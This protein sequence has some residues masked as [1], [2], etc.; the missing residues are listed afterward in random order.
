MEETLDRIK[1]TETA[2]TKKQAQRTAFF[3]KGVTV[4]LLSGISYG[5]YSAF[6]T[7]A[8][9]KGVWGDWYG[10]N[11]FGLSVFAITFLI[12]TLGSGVNDAC[13]AIWA[14]ANAAKQGKAKEFFRSV[15]TKPGLMMILAALVGGPIASAAY[16]IA[17]QMAGSIVIPI[18][19]LCPAIG[20]I[21]SRILFK[22]PLEKRQLIG[23][24][25][26]IA[27]SILIGSTGFGADAPDGLLAGMLIALIAAFGW[28]LEGCVGGYAVAMIDSNIGIIIR[29]TTSAL[30]NLLLLMPILGIIEGGGVGQVVTLATQA[31]TDGSAMIFFAISGFFALFAYSLW[32][33]GN[34]MCG[35]PL[36]MACN[37]TYSFWGPFFCWIILGVIVGLPGWDLAPIVWIG[38]LVMAFGILVIAMNPLD[39]LRKKAKA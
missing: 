37:A 26:C 36:G 32:Y 9:T 14:F 16:V 12:P 8:M 7:L 23:I 15:P 10:P 33:K 29:Q 28:G 18:T 6:M 35:A 5:L 4:A 38:A 3:R 24:A 39:L 1:A 20:S 2:D 30:A 21:L 27:A 11:V 31:F 22:Q 34:S 25:I 19:A 13:S 17:L